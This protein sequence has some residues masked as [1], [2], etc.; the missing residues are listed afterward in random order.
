[1]VF[2]VALAVGVPALVVGASPRFGAIQALVELVVGVTYATVALWLGRQVGRP[3][4][5][6][7]LR[8]AARC[9]VLVV[10]VLA[11]AAAAGRRPP[12]AELLVVAVVLAG[13]G[14]VAVAR[15]GEATAATASGRRPLMTWMG[16]V[17]VVV[18]ALLVV[19]AAGALVLTGPLH[20]PLI[21]TIGALRFAAA[22]IGYLLGL[23]GYAVLWVVATL[24][25]LTGLHLPSH[26]PPHLRSFA[27]GQQPG[28]TEVPAAPVEAFLLLVLALVVA[29]AVLVVWLLLRR[30]RGAV[31][32][33][34]EERESL[35]TA[36]EAA[37]RAVRRLRGAM[38]RLV[39]RTPRPT[40]P[41]AAVRLEYRRLEGRLARKG[42]RR[43]VDRSARSFLSA[44]GDEAVRGAV[45]ALVACYERA[46]YGGRQPS[47]ADVDLF[48]AD[49]DRLLAALTPPQRSERVS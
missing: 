5:A 13:V 30:R 15:A 43:A 10:V 6:S 41:D 21:W 16:G 1:V 24:A 42:Y 32:T 3:T 35:L 28:T 7:A 48:R 36:G 37:G 19:A 26:E 34:P 31:E 2:G 23:A 33:S 38:A 14:Q 49:A 12:T 27:T 4:A 20:D 45:E 46:R 22:G 44:L 29:A 25:G 11:V 18:L 9:L 39:R 8:R 40:S 47:W 17:A